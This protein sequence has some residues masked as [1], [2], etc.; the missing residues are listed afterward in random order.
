[1]E[2]SAVPKAMA[3]A[4]SVMRNVKAKGAAAGDVMDAQLQKQQAEL[5]HAKKAEEL[6]KT[7][8]AEPFPKEVRLWS[9]TDVGRWLDTLTLSQYVQAFNEASVDGD[10]LLEL[11]IR[12]DVALLHASRSD[13]AGNLQ[14]RLSSR[15]FNPVV[16]LAGEVVL[17]Q[18]DEI[19][20]I[21]ELL[22]QPAGRRLRRPEA[23]APGTM[24]AFR[25]T[26]RSRTTRRWRWCRPCWPRTRRPRRYGKHSSAAECKGKERY[27]ESIFLHIVFVS[28]HGFQ[29]LQRS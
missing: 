23:S 6:A 10:F 28:L 25:C 26:S 20:E 17:A 1:M 4:E 19:V 12:A 21:G 24:A 13:R 9:V 2:E 5:D 3:K 7:S 8:K 29:R 14:Y 16:A 15:N 22:L 11:P 27:S 18:A